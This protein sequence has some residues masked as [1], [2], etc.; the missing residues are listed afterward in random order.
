VPRLLS[1]IVAIL[2]K[3]LNLSSETSLH[4]KKA[5]NTEE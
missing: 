1:G 3:R 4:F 5:V 2:K